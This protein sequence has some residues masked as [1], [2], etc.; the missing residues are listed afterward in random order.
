M[1]DM[2]LG[3]QCLDTHLVC[4]QGESDRHDLSCCGP[5][6]LQV[7][8]ILLVVALQFVWLM[9]DPLSNCPSVSERVTYSG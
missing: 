2:K 9:D 7:I 8:I 5:H 1:V 6:A 4:L 3:R